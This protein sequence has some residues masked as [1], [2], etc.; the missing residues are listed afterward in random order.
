MP[1][2]VLFPAIERPEAEIQLV[3]LH[4]AG[5]SSYPYLQLAH[6]LSGFIEV[7]CLELAGRGARFSEPFQADVETVLSDICTSIKHLGLGDNKPLLLCGH[8]LG[9]ELAYQV[10]YRLEREAPE[11]QFSLMISARGFI[12]PGTLG[13][14]RN[15]VLSDADILRLLEQYEGT[16]SEVLADPEWRKY[17]IGVMRNDL[18]LLASLSRLPKPV[19]NVQ[20][21]LVG[22]N[23]DKRVP[24]SQLAE[25]R[26]AFTVP[27]T[28]KIFTGG[29][30]YLFTS[31]EVIPWIEERA[32]ELAEQTSVRLSHGY[33]TE[34][35]CALNDS[36]QVE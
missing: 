29:H 7:Y 34:C 11:K 21:H 6:K 32:R 35:R 26:R 30:F 31:D 28:Q 24:V 33:L 15:E 36:N 17:V 19:L 14:E 10:A 13:S 1:N 23:Q 22:G 20:T 8:S 18:S 27:V 12:E 25:W 9:A 5:G 4:H 2:P 3:F 16:P